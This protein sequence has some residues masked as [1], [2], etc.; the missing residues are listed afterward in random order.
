MWQGMARWLEGLASGL[1]LRPKA[2]LVVSAHWEDECFTLTAS[3][4]P[5]LIY[6]YHGFPPHTYVLRYPVKG[7]PW[8][9]HQIHERLCA[10][11]LP[12]ALDEARGLDHGAFIPFKL[13]YPFAD[14]PMVQLSLRGDLDPAAHLAAGEA[15]AGLRDEGVLI[16]GSGMSFHNMRPTGERVEARAQEFDDWLTETVMQHPSERRQRLLH[17]SEA[18]QARF[19]HPREEHFLPLLVACG[20]AVDQPARRIY[21]ERLGGLIAVS[22]FR[23]G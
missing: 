21:A 20:A 10:A 23:F 6:D 18:P 22:A 2:I 13:I 19:S 15:L 14:I 17:W 8:L 16:V 9:A 5:E 11:G 7:A 4:S 1:P 12:A 3:E